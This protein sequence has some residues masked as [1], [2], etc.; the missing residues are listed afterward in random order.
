LKEDGTKESFQK[1]GYTV[2]QNGEIIID[3]ESFRST[4][5][6]ANAAQ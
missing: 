1:P 3:I 6:G 5:L 2:L 4:V